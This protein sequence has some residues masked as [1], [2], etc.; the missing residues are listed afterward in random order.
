MLAA[1]VQTNIASTAS[2]SVGFP[3]LT[4]LILLPAAGAILT[5]F[6]PRRRPELARVVGYVTSMTTFALAVFMLVKFDTNPLKPGYQM[7]E[8]HSWIN[9]L[10]VHWTLGVDGISLFLVV[11][12]ALLIPIGFLASHKIENPKAF[13]F[14]TL[15][16]ESAVIGVFLALDAIVFFMFFEF[17]LVPMYFLIA[18][19]GHG[20][21][22][23][24]AMKFFLFTMAGSAFLFAGILTVAFA[25]PARRAPADVQRAD[26]H[27]LGVDQGQPLDQHRAGVVPRV[28]RRVRG[29][30]AAVPVPHVAARRA[31]RRADRGLGRAGRRD[32]EDG[33][34]RVLAV[35]D[36]VLPEAARRSRAA[37]ARSGRH[38]H[39]LRRD[40]R[41]DAAEPETHHR[42]LVGRAPRF[43][44]AR[45]LRAHAR[46][47]S[48]AAC[49]RWS[50]TGSRRVRSSCS[51]ACSTTAGTLTR[52]PKFR[53]LWKAVP[54][55]GGLVR[56]GHVRVD[57]TA[58]LLRLRR[59]VPVVARRVPR[60]RGGTRSSPRRA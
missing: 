6:V 49:S 36:P 42:V 57:R 55:F 8:D 4:A 19:W 33:R 16:L 41:R 53:G 50:R 34:L 18:G 48:R 23:Y 15:F 59:R 54:V 30:G 13:V 37:P 38:R 14:W 25:V 52:S 28:R 12:P 9:A 5:L 21:R 45:H 17:V 26:P 20:R 43:R 44:G 31:H 2:S 7:F 22:R 56:G 58:G 27:R 24:A 11:L 32:A 40:R 35:R 3:L 60:A 29:E 1:L 47:A 39:H 51:S 46:K 10:G